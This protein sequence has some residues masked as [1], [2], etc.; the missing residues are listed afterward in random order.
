[1]LYLVILLSLI[2]HR[3]V[4]VFNNPGRSSWE[5]SNK[6]NRCLPK[7]VVNI[8]SCLALCLR[9]KNPTPGF[10][11]TS[12]REALTL[13]EMTLSWRSQISHDIFALSALKVF[14]GFIGP[15]KCVWRAI[16]RRHK[17]LISL[18]QSKFKSAEY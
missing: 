1:V 7:Y 8:Y 2:G 10:N 12:T 5:L 14:F 9:G 3:S 16:A 13:I 6:L 15:L 18:Y 4:S 17:F 11:G